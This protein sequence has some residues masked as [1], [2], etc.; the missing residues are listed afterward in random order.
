MGGTDGAFPDVPFVSMEPLV[1][2]LE[3]SMNSSFASAIE[4]FFSS[5]DVLLTTIVEL[6]LIMK[7]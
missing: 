7:R 4:G 2:S 1:A 6:R 3:R 5:V